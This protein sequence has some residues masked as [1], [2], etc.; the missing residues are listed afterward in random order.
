M[1][2]GIDVR[3][4]RF[5][6]IHLPGREADHNTVA[7]A[8]FCHIRPMKGIRP[9]TLIRGYQGSLSSRKGVLGCNITAWILIMELLRNPDGGGLTSRNRSTLAD[10]VRGTGPMTWLLEPMAVVQTS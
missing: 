4:R 6:K 2:S 9:E 3:V 1:A 8:G 10:T 7:E 5:S